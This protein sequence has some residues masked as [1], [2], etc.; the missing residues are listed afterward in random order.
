MMNLKLRAKLILIFLAVKVLP[1]VL[2]V[3]IAWTQ[4]ISLGR[5]LRDIAVSDSSKALN[6]GAIENIERLTTDTAKA[7]AKFL[8]QRD[9]DILLL[10]R[11]AQQEPSED[12]YRIFTEGR[13]GRLKRKG[14][15]VIAPDN[16]SWVPVDTYVYDGIGG[17]SS[18]RENDRNDAFRY[19]PPDFFLA[20]QRAVV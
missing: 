5:M 16:M 15:W 20:R 7:V 3:F 13:L 4:I 6:D 18:N 10:A 1:I 14:E 9:D 19:R 8:Y 11:L 12:I 2:L 17:K